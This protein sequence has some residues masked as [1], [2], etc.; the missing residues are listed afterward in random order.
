LAGD[1][2]GLRVGVERLCQAI[3]SRLFNDDFESHKAALMNFDDRE[4]EST[5]WFVDR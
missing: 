4:L 5:R 1:I 3:V 2:P